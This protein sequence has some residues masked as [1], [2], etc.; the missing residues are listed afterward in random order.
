[1]GWHSM[2]MPRCAPQVPSTLSIVAFAALLQHLAPSWFGDTQFSSCH[3][4]DTPEL[5]KGSQD[6][7]FVHRQIFEELGRAGR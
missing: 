5:G 1:M 2:N 3:G 4:Q 6:C 7:G